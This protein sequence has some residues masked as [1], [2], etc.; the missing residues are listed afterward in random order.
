[1]RAAL[2]GEDKQ[3]A[4]LRFE[5][6]TPVAKLLGDGPNIAILDKPFAGKTKDE[7]AAL[8]PNLVGKTGGLRMPSTEW[9]FGS[10]TPLAPY[11]MEGKVESLTFSIP[12]KTP[13]S[14]TEIMKLVEA[15][16]GKSK[17]EV[18]FAS[19]SGGKTFVY[20]KKD[21]HI[22]VTEGGSYNKDTI[23]IRIGGK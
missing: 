4:E 19:A 9:E 10:G 20:N 18:P 11:P 2:S 23:K 6:Y 15:K 13:E 14:R 17:G 16:W 3:H 7:I 1:V 8:Y 5:S 12:F 22:E 21:P